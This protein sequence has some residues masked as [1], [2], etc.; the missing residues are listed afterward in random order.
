MVEAYRAYRSD[1][2]TAGLLDEAEVNGWGYD[3]LP[4]LPDAAVKIF[5][6]NAE[7]YPNSWRVY[8]AMGDAYVKTGQ[9]AEAIMDYGRS[10]ELNPD[11]QSVA[12]KI[13][14]LREGG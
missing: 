4:V 7:S 14:R 13:K 9:P 11:N 5:Q 6:L 10:L 2:A 8:E 1:P 3:T 12:D